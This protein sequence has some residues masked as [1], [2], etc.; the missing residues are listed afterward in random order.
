MRLILEGTAP[1][2]VLRAE[3][4]ADNFATVQENR[5]RNGD[6]VKFIEIMNNAENLYTITP[7]A[8]TDEGLNAIVADLIVKIEMYWEA[9]S[10]EPIPYLGHEFSVDD[11]VKVNILGKLQVASV[12]ESVNGEGTFSTLWRNVNR[13]PVTMNMSELFSFGLAI[14]EQI[15]NA[16]DSSNNHILQV[17]AIAESNNDNSTKLAD[18]NAYDYTALLIN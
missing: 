16:V 17:T 18:L 9:K 11:R 10:F 13:A 14:G 2:R 6:D 4:R 5:T 3:N 8:E 15:Q 1:A 12:H 7:W